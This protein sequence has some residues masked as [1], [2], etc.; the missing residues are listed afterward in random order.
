MSRNREA[1]RLKKNTRHIWALNGRR[2]LTYSLCT[3]RCRPR[4]PYDRPRPHN[5]AR[6]VPLFVRFGPRGN[7][8]SSRARP[9]AAAAAGAASAA[10]AAATA[11]TAAGAAAAAAAAAAGATAAPATGYPRAALA[12]SL[13]GWSYPRGSGAGVSAAV[14]RPT[15]GCPAALSAA[16]RRASR[17]TCVNTQ[18]APNRHMPFLAHCRHSPSRA[19]AATMRATGGW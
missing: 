3:S 1:Q 4:T 10:A 9:P 7:R 8:G 17:A 2:P 14:G 5:G 12:L 6:P 11:A 15:P 16:P 13:F 18:A 19:P